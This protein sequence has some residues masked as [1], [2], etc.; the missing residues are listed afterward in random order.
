[1]QERELDMLISKRWDPRKGVS[2]QLGTIRFFVLISFIGIFIIGEIVSVP[3]LHLFWLITLIIVWLLPRGIRIRTKRKLEPHHWFLCLWCRYPLDG[4]D[5]EGVCPEC[6]TGY[7]KDVCVNLYRSAYRGYTP[8]PAVL[9]EREKELWREA[10]K[11]R[12]GMKDEGTI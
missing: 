1:M 7:R 3:Y 10:I 12:D 8:D 6:G 5:D 9:I 2:K 11:L 4:L